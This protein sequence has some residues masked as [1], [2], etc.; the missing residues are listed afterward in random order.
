MD[1][2]RLVSQNQEEQE[3]DFMNSECAK[4]EVFTTSGDS[5]HRFQ[6]CIR[7]ILK[8][9]PGNRYLT[10]IAEFRLEIRMILKKH[11]EIAI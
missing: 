5:D 8:R 4:R 1:P 9:N 10:K 7:I 11:S 3:S 6:V 2:W